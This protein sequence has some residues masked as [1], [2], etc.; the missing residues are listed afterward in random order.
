MTRRLHGYLYTSQFCEENIWHLASSLIQQDI[1]KTD[2]TVVF[3]SNIKQH[4]ALFNQKTAPDN[5]PVIW[6]YHVILIQQN[7]HQHLVFDFDSKCDFPVTLEE[8]L[9]AS[10]PT[11]VQI[12]PDYQA[13]FRLVKASDFLH[14]FYSDRSHM[15][16]L[17]DKQSFPDY[18][19][20]NQGIENT[21]PLAQYVNFSQPLSASEKILNQDQLTRH[22]SPQ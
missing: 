19:P 11:A 7:R 21:R 13:A 10:L 15:T 4:V 12:H 9:L 16:G 1:N 20:V 17:I 22:F 3:I 6:D 8:Y 14:Q 5:Q 2:L 18:T